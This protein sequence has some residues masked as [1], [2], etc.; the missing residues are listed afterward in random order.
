MNAHSCRSVRSRTYGPPQPALESEPARCDKPFGAATLWLSQAALGEDGERV[1]VLVAGRGFNDAQ[2]QKS[3]VV[4]QRCG[5]DEVGLWL[6]EVPLD[7]VFRR[8][9]AGLW[10]ELMMAAQALRV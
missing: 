10:E 7:T 5:D 4:L 8:D 9:S 1:T 2:Y 3:V 6:F